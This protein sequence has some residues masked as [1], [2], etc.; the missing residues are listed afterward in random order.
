MYRDSK[1][2]R[3]RT[4]KEIRDELERK[5]V[6]SQTAM[7]QEYQR[8]ARLKIFNLSIK[9]PENYM[10]ELSDGMEK[11]VSC[12]K[13]QPL[14]TFPV[15]PSHCA[16]TENK[17]TQIIP[18]DFF[19]FDVAVVPHVERLIGRVCEQVSKENIK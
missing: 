6:D 14:R 12:E 7:Y 11:E 18:G 5:K 19:D 2:K 15:A 13:T 1:H 16:E 9:A 8:F 10:L 4:L 3:R 17:G